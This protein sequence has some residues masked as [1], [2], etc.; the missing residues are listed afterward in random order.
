M[1]INPLDAVTDETL[2]IG[3]DMC[4]IDQSASRL[5][6]VGDEYLDKMKDRNYHT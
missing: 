2:Q 6:Y 5:K 4:A 3:L 1:P